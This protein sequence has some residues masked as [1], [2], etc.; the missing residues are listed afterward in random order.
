MSYRALIIAALALWLFPLANAQSRREAKN[1]PP[2]PVISQTIE[3]RRG[4]QVAIPLG[5]HGAR[6]EMLEFLIRTPPTHG[7]LSAVK[8]TAMNTATVTYIS[9][10]RGAADGDRF[11][12]AVHSSEGVSAPGLIT[13]R[14]VEP[15]VA[16]AKSALL[17]MTRSDSTKLRLKMA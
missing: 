4:G 16:P 5:I 11:A 10:T 8:N 15:V 12:S 9:S 3:M 13:I 7:R 14:F 6:G 2:P 1:A 17:R